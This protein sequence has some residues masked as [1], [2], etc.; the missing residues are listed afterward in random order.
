[1]SQ[2]QSKMSPSERF[3]AFMAS[4]TPERIAEIDRKLNDPVHVGRE[5]KWRDDQD[6]FGRNWD[7]LT[8]EPGVG[9]QDGASPTT[10]QH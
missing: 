8:P 5:V 3:R 9:E 1:M 2:E 7:W 4:I 6:P 10:E